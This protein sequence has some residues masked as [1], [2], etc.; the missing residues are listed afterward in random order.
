[1]Q[2]TYDLRNDLAGKYGPWAVIAGGSEGVGESFARMLAST[3]I[4]LLLL[5]RREGPLQQLAASIREDSG[6]GEDPF[7][8]SYRPRADG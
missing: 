8:R 2:S 5:A 1:M 4:N 3:G 7:G 6:G